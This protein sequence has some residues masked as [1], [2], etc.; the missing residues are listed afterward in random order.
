MHLFCRVPF[1]CYQIPS[2]RSS[3]WYN[4]E[5]L[6]IAK[7][8]LNN[9]A[10]GN[11]EAEQEKNMFLS[12]GRCCDYNSQTPD[13]QRGIL[14]HSN[15]FPKGNCQTSATPSWDLSAF[16]CRHWADMNY[17]LLTPNQLPQTGT[18]YLS[19]TLAT[20]GLTLSPS[21]AC[22]PLKCS[23][24]RMPGLTAREEKSWF[25]SKKSTWGRLW[26]YSALYI[27][28]TLTKGKFSSATDFVFQRDITSRCRS[29]EAG[30]CSPTLSDRVK[31]KP[32]E[33]WIW[34][35]LSSFKG[36]GSSGKMP[37]VLNVW[38]FVFI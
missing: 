35:I 13:H 32:A 1:T 27:L 34:K 31:T 23:L 38:K 9:K 6:C 28:L 11:T 29:E 19:P 22:V 14:I 26:D 33:C 12:C 37:W 4:I 24:R 30:V 7:I 10:K 16:W 2:I 5:L 8:S 36:Q 18:S 15:Y 20:R 3:H 25:W 17:H 21:P